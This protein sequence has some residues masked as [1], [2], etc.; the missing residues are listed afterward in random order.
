MSR[1]E[2][3]SYVA[4]FENVDN[5]GQSR[6]LTREM[7]RRWNRAAKPGRPP[8]DVAEK[9]V[10]VMLTMTPDLL[11]KADAFAK[12]S[13]LSRSGLVKAALLNQMKPPA[14]KRAS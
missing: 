9:S 7:R 12:K 3:D 6:P 11:R 4:Q 1:A 10:K 13:G 8:K 14:K 2:F 5:L